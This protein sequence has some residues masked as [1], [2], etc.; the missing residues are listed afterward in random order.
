LRNYLVAMLTF[1]GLYG[2]LALG[3]NLIWG[4]AGMIN[5]GLV[6]FFAVGGYVSALATLQLGVPIPAGVGIAMLASALAG[7]VMALVTARLRGDYLAII[8]LGFSEVVRLVASNEIWLTRGTDGISGIPGPWR[9]RVAPETF[10]LIYLGIVAAVV[11]LLVLVLERVRTAPYGRVLRAI[12]DDEQVAAVAGKPVTA[13][14][15]QAFAVSSAILGLGGA[16]YG[17]YTSFVAPDSF[18]TLVSIYVVLAV[19]AGGT[20]TNTGAVLGAALVVFFMEST[21]F[22]TG[23]LPLEP[24]QVAALREFLIGASLIAVMRFRPDG[25]VPERIRRVPVPPP[26]EEAPAVAP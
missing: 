17:H 10:N 15:V 7:V 3:L 19:T 5:L 2:I 8:T 9:G 22:A 26:V 21:R 20:G 18:T 4:M 24:V 12:R 16:L 6:G 13:F 11:A 25:L 23:W 1:A 14:K